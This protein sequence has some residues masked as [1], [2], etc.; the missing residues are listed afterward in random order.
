[1]RALDGHEIARRAF[2]RAL[3]QARVG[4]VLIDD[5]H[6]S[7]E[8]LRRHGRAVEQ[9]WP[10][11]ERAQAQ[12]HRREE[13]GDGRYESQGRRARADGQRR[14]PQRHERARI[15]GLEG[16]RHVGVKSAHEGGRHQRAGAAVA[17]ALAE[18]DRRQQIAGERRHERSGAPRRRQVVAQQTRRSQHARGHG[19]EAERGERDGGHRGPKACGPDCRRR[20]GEAEQ[21][22]PAHRGAKTGRLDHGPHEQ[23]PAQRGE[24]GPDPLELR[25]RGDRAPHSSSK[26]AARGRWWSRVGVA[27]TSSPVGD[28]RDVVHLF[29]V[30]R[31]H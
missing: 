24:E 17:R 6:V 7:H 12:R 31:L 16:P 29:S 28:R 11:S 25:H 14:R 2:D 8:R 10:V 1:M 30:S 19:A 15:D 23:A 26:K 13:P 4:R 20:R 21:S 9:R 5:A 22:Q 18:L 27:A 3:R